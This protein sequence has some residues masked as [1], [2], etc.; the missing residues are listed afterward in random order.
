M[1]HAD[2][3]RD[4]GPRLPSCE[5]LLPK[6]QRGLKSKENQRVLTAISGRIL[7]APQ[8]SVTFRLPSWLTATDP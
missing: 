8:A 7:P 6:D 1:I 3:H 2:K 5:P 4:L